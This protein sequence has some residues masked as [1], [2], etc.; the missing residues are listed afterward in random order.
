[1]PSSEKSVSPKPDSRILQKYCEDQVVQEYRDKHDRID[2]GNAGFTGPVELTLFVYGFT[3]KFY[4]QFFPVVLRMLIVSFVAITDVVLWR[5]LGMDQHGLG[6]ISVRPT[7]VHIWN[8]EIDNLPAT[9]GPNT[10]W[11][12]YHVYGEMDIPF[13]VYAV[14]QLCQH[15]FLGQSYFAVLGKHRFMLVKRLV[16]WQV[17]PKRQNVV[18]MDCATKPGDRIKIVFDIDNQKMH[19][20]LIQL[21]D[22]IGQRKMEYRGSCDLNILQWDWNDAACPYHLRVR[23]LEGANIK[24]NSYS[25]E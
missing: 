24:F 7:G 15:G 12:K 1:M 8:W 17:K 14:I 9:Q 5:S 22:D 4:A 19:C 11:G 25:M 18:T 16:K 13:P 2:R 20:V 3:R 10:Y 23:A 6:T 21:N